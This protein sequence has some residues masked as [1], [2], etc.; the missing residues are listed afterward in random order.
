MLNC[1]TKLLYIEYEVY[2]ES[3]WVVFDYTTFLP[4]QPALVIGLMATL[5]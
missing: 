1:M 3:V 2:V 5:N 4:Q